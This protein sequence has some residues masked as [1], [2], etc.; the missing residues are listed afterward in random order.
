MLFICLLPSWHLTFFSVLMALILL[1]EYY[2]RTAVPH[3]RSLRFRKPFDV[4]PHLLLVF[5][6]TQYYWYAVTCS[7]FW[8]WLILNSLQQ[9]M[10]SM[11]ILLLIVTFWLALKLAV[12]CGLVFDTAMKRILN[13]LWLWT[14]WL[15][16]FTCVHWSLICSDTHTYAMILLLII[17]MK[18]VKAFSHLIASSRSQTAAIVLRAS[19][20]TV[21]YYTPRI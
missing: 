5:N 12:L 1:I 8:N 18:F 3:K 9:R 7:F 20:Q 2:W 4:E 11:K 6:M 15:D 17:I 16:V 13:D 10:S 14:M 21:S 19:L